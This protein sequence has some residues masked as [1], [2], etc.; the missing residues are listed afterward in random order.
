M[1]SLTNWFEESLQDLKINDITRAYVVGV[2]A[3]FRT[4]K[5]D[6]SNHSITLLFAQARQNNSFL[7]YQKIGDWIFWSSVWAREHLNSASFDYYQSVG[8]ISYYSC[9][10]LLQRQ[11]K[12]F[13]ELA[14]RFPYL[15]EKSRQL[16]KHQIIG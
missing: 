15:S 11:L 10:R 14:D 9:Y 4:S 12:V 13:E 7:E 16:L 3:S 5:P 1:T 8:Q 2:F 6:L